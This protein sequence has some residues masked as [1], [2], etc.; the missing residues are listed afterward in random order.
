MIL[1]IL[2]YYVVYVIPRF[3]VGAHD[4]DTLSTIVC[5]GNGKKV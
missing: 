1:T 3:Y 5:K 4:T 2:S